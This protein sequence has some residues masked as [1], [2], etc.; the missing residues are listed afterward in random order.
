[1]TAPW[2]ELDRQ[3]IGR[4]ELSQQFWESQTLSYENTVFNNIGRAQTLLTAQCLLL[5]DGERYT[6]HIRNPT[7][8]L[9][10]VQL[11][12]ELSHRYPGLRKVASTT[13][14]F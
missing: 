14:Y 6:A 8:E 11:P 7:R 10:D 5:T 13:L 2:R 12:R 9:Q 4:Q 3:E 1:M